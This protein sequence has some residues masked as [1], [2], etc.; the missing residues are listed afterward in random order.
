[1]NEYDLEK[2]VDDLCGIAE[3]DPILEELQEMVNG[4]RET[5]KRNTSIEQV[6][7]F[8]YFQYNWYFISPDCSICFFVIDWVSWW[9][10]F[11]CWEI[12]LKIMEISVLDSVLIKQLRWGSL[13]FCVQFSE[14]VI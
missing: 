9:D 6:A 11:S 14:S 2:S 10:L 12:K 3:W 4:V 13:F 1:M 7:I 5:G 8:Y